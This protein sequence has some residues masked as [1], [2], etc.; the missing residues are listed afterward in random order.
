MVSTLMIASVK[1]RLYCTA[2]IILCNQ[3]NPSE[4]NVLIHK[5]II[6]WGFMNKNF[7]FVSVFFIKF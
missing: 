2:L 7:H 3:K 1:L 6:K 5:L 4:F